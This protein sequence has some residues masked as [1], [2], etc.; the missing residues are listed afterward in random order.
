M[1]RIDKT[2]P[3]TIPSMQRDVMDG[4][5]SEL[6]SMSGAV[7]RMGRALGIPTPAHDF[8][9]AALLPQEQ[10]ARQQR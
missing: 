2:A 9:Y 4:R 7:A 8:L 3:A 1:K 6:E 10:S 5:P